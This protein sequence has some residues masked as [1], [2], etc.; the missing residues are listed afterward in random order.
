MGSSGGLAHAD[1]IADRYRLRRVLKRSGGVETLLVNSIT[2]GS[3]IVIKR[4]PSDSMSAALGMRLA[5]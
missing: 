3:A 1:L 5:H 4:A 2:D